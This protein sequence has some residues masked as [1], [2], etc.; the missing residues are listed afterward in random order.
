[1]GESE[2]VARWW[3]EVGVVDAAGAGR[4]LLA[5]ARRMGVSVEGLPDEY[6]HF[7][8]ELQT[9]IMEKAK[10]GRHATVLGDGG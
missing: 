10:S 9:E 8:G 7:N 6:E 3:R 2:V 5:A 1:M 4:W